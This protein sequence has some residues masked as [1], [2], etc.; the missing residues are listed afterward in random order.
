MFKDIQRKIYEFFL[1]FRLGNLP[2]TQYKERWEN[3]LR[4][5][6]S[7]KQDSFIQGFDDFEFFKDLSLKTAVSIKFQE[8]TPDF[9]YAIVLFSVAREYVKQKKGP[10]TV[11]ETGTAKGFSAL[12]LSRATILEGKQASIYT[13]DIVPHEHPRFWNVFGDQSS[14]KRT[15]AELLKDYPVETQR[16]KFL[17]GD[18]AET[19]SQLNTPRIHIGFLDAMHEYIP[20]RAEFDYVS[21]RQKAGDLVIFDDVMPLKFPGVHKLVEEVEKGQ[22]YNVRRVTSPRGNTVAIATRQ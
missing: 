15:R 8:K 5:L 11:L 2:D 18:S 4:A 21:S 22:T 7:H 13:L 12:L 17:S 9:Y 3:G 14:G 19:M 20:L 16:I 1:G 6:E 10:L